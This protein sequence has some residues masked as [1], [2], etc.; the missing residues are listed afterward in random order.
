SVTAILLGG[1]ARYW[2][3]GKLFPSA[4][5]VKAEGQGT[6]GSGIPRGPQAQ[7]VRVGMIEQK[8][9]VPVR[10]LVGDLIAVRRATIASEVAGKMVE[11]PV[12]EGTHV[13]EGETLLARIDDTWPNIEVDKI[14]T[15][16]AEKRATLKFE[17]TDL[18]RF[19]E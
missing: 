15:Q 6:G 9:I 12:D 11:L 16:I 7:L 4:A 14:I 2:A 19:E 13:I 1:L 18:K 3:T 10:T 17:R 5:L 8:S